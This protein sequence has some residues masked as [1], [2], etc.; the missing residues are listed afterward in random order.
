MEKPITGAGDLKARMEE[1]AALEAAE[2]R[3]ATLGR[4]TKMGGILSDI[5][6]VTHAIERLQSF[7]H[8]QDQRIPLRASSSKRQTLP[9]MPARDNDM[10]ELNSIMDKLS[11]VQGNKDR[12][13][14]QRIDFSQRRLSK[15]PQ[16]QQQQLAESSSSAQTHAKLGRRHLDGLSDGTASQGGAPDRESELSH[17][18]PGPVSHAAR[19]RPA[20]DDRLPPSP[21]DV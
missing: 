10:D 13:D 12:L 1:Q 7:N 11:R 18:V 16:Q 19:T 3:A 8:M 14:G 9:H 20:L 21:R 5:D 4:K 15:L 6:T 2:R 17:I